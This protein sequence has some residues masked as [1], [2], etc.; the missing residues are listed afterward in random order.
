MPNGWNFG[1]PHSRGEFARQAHVGLPEGTYEREMGKEGFFGAASHLYHRNPPTGWSEIS[2]DLKPRAF[3]PLAGDT[4]SAGPWYAPRLLGNSHV[5]LSVVR[6]GGAMNHLV[7]NADGDTLLFVH[8]GSADLHC[9][10]GHLAVVPGDYLLVPRGTMWRLDCTAGFEMLMVQST[11]DA[12]DLPQRGIVG[13][14]APFDIGMLDIP[15]MDDA[16]RAQQQP[17]PWTVHVKRSGKVSVLSYPYNPLDAIGWKG[18]LFPVRLNIRDI[19]AIT[20]DGLH[21]PPSLRTTFVSRRFVVCSLIPR[22]LETDPKAIKLPFFHNN[23]DFDEV[24]FQHEGKMSSR[25]HSVRPGMVTFHPSGITHGPH[26]EVLPHMYVNKSD[27]T[28]GYAVMIDTRD[29]LELL[30]GAVDCDVP[31]YYKS[32]SMVPKSTPRFEQSEATS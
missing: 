30:E 31:G 20:S 3:E 21:L 5:E 23:D 17:K 24:I 1:G 10:F 11:G 13:R 2:G 26:P 32:W 8:H 15:E 29:P 19:K 14:H 16:F 27:R 25:A 9:D 12:F 4:A 18:D 28:E 7:R 22:V 6:L